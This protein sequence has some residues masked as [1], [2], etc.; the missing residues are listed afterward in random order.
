[1]TERAEQL[2]DD[3]PLRFAQVLRQARRAIPADAASL[4]NVLRFPHRV[5][6]S[7]SQEEV[8][9]A[10]GISRV[11]YATLESGRAARASIALLEKLANVLMLTAEQRTAVFQ[12][13]VPELSTRDLEA[14]NNGI[15][16]ASVQLRKSMRRLWSAASVEEAL[17]IAAEEATTHFADAELVLYV[18][19]I[20]EGEWE[21]PVLVDRRGIGPENAGLYSDLAAQVGRERF[22]QVAL[23]PALAQPGDVGTRATFAATAIADAYEA[24]VVRHNLDR[25]ALL[26]ARIRSR[27]GVIAGL[28]VKHA[29]EREYTETERAIIGAI[30]SLAS[31]AIS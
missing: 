23:Y 19:R 9:E 18:R 1:V 29:S 11:W 5:G 26:H 6:R 8:A 3:R 14:R 12:L 13:A 28:T 21:H 7:V 31:L 24:A 10:V 16:Q 20:A 30:A 22:D 25:W 2:P 15:L 27:D 4:G 17:A